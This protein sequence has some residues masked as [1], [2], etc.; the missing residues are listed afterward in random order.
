M[1]QYESFTLSLKAMLSRLDELQE[2]Y[3]SD[4]DKA[5]DELDRMED[6]LED[7]GEELSRFDEYL[8]S[9]NKNPDYFEKKDEE[10]QIA[11]KLYKRAKKTIACLRKEITGYDERQIMRMMYPD[12][13]IDSD[14]FEDG[15]DMED[16]YDENE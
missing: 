4:E 13:D 5:L 16:F 15:F 14:D 8:Y 2:T 1:E 6:R 12:D 3:S 7:I 11:D 9:G 10:C